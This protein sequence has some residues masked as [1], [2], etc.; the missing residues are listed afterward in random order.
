MYTFWLII[1][2]VTLC[3]TEEE[4][5]CPNSYVPG[6]ISYKVGSTST[7][8]YLIQAGGSNSWGKVTASGSS[9][10]IGK[11]PRFY[12]ASGCVSAFAGNAFSTFASLVGG[13]ISFTVDVSQLGCGTNAAFYLVN[14]PTSGAGS[15]GDYYCDANC[16]G[17]SCCAEMDLLEA[18]RWALQI[19]PHKCTSATGGCDAGG[20]G[21][22]TQSLGKTAYGPGSSYTINT[23]SAYNVKIAFSGSGSALTGITTTISQGSK[24]ITLS[25]SDSA[26]GSGYMSA[27]GGVLKAGMVPVWSYWTGNMAWLDSP[28][29]S[30]ENNEVAGNFIFSNL[31]VSGTVG[32]TTGPPSQPPSGPPAPPGTPVCGT[33]GTTTNQYWVEFKAPSGVDGSKTSA[34]VKCTSGSCQ[35]CTWF[36]SGGKYQ[37]SCPG[38]G[39]TNPTITVGG[40]A[41]VLSAS[42]LT[43]DTMANSSTMDQPMIIGVS[44]VAAVLVITIIVIVVI[45][46]KKKGSPEIA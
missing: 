40:K 21:K 22:N 41:C 15:N 5:T 3:L 43:E 7:T 34:S 8:G 39:C 4:A 14:M 31:V 13:S 27:F 16:V 46:L 10:T 35:A 2:A 29:C 19:S 44:V 20:C 6:S 37:C 26:C 36:A 25:Q 23:S 11:G 18:N 30:N 45:Y 32:K 1:A 28:A 38:S 17:G 42:A 33:S 24:S 9:V 12:L